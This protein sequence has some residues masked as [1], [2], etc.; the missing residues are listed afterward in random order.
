VTTVGEWLGEA[1][2][3]K[4][5]EDSIDGGTTDHGPL[6]HSVSPRWGHSL[7]TMCS[8]HGMFPAKLVHYFVQRYTRH[9]D[10][11]L[12]PFSGRGTTTL[13]ARVEGRRTISNDLNP[14]AYV[15]TRAKAAPPSWDTV[16][17]AVDALERTFKRRLPRG[18]DAPSDIQMLYHDNTLRQIVFLRECLLRRPRSRWTR[19][20]L[21]IAGATAG[22]L[23]G[24]HRNDGSSQYLS[25]SMPNT[26]SMSP[27]YVERFIQT[28][29]LKKPDQDVFACLRDKLARLY[30]DEIPGT[31]GQVSNQDG[32]DL[33]ASQTIRAGSVDLVVTSPPYLQVVNYGTANWIRL[34]WLGLDEVSRNAGMG[35]R[36]LDAKLDHG[37][38]YQSYAQFMLRTLKGVHR[39]LART[40]VAAVVIGDVTVPGRESI[41]LARKVWNDIGERTGLRLL[42][43]IE[44]SLPTHNKVS[45]IWGDTRGKA[46]DRDC[47]LLMARS[48]GEP[49][50]NNPDVEWDEPYKEAGPDAAH[51]RVRQ[52]RLVS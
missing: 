36:K 42:D 49:A 44:D 46:T 1:F 47:V 34:W 3:E 35:R 18:V 41:P 30:L 37:H 20:E 50:I 24:A 14:L 52:S 15:L 11:V 51:T 8:Y 22:I 2:F 21:M 28:N 19:E 45:R 4:P 5:E 43:V 9:G 10:L 40:G 25:I 48:D 13:Q 33:L 17:S 16:M 6:W 27:A 29:G 38:T 31:P 32:P 39:V 26:F 12:D 7:H 23:H